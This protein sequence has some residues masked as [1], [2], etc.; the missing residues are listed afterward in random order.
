[1]A[2]KVDRARERELKF[3]VD[4]AFAVPDLD[5]WVLGPRS[6][7]VLTADY[8]DTADLRLL[9][10]G[11]SL[12][13]RRAS[14]GSEDGWT[15]KLKS[16]GSGG[17]AKGAS[18]DE[19][20]V[21][22]SPDSPPSELRNLVAAYVR[23]GHLARQATLV[24]VRRSTILGREGHAGRYELADD[25][26]TSRI[27]PKA[28]PTFRQVEVEA[29]G[30]TSTEV[31]AEVADTHGVVHVDGVDADEV[32][33]D[34][35]GIARA[36][37]AA[38]AG[39]A[40]STPKVALVLADRLAGPEVAGPPL[41]HRST[42]ADLVGA[43]L[44]AGLRRLVLHDP[45]VRLGED[46]DAVHQARVGTRRLRSDLR[47]LS[48]LLE[49]APVKRWRSELSW[50]GGLLGGV[51]DLDVLEPRLARDVELLSDADGLPEAVGKP[52]HDRAPAGAGD[53][54]AR[55]AIGA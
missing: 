11:H 18:R 13:Y 27:G 50:L 47:T 32:D 52:G 54:L 55:G 19:L 20:D 14:D 29:V 30:P 9:R 51:R 3:E 33:A 36:M 44:A 53:V 48:P 41:D 40:G 45:Y 10:W 39:P 25:L 24:T 12:R 23:R 31:I 34:L 38:G 35:D 22:G 26:V 46:P 8:W 4:E 16:A 2:G 17:A 1:M 43:S 42:V 5:G 15:L 49:E 7:V 6:E 21:A 28:G 37:E